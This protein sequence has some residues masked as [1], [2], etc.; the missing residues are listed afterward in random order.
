MNPDCEA[1]DS[2]KSCFII[3]R[4]FSLKPKMNKQKVIVKKNFVKL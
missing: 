2:F 1:S 3:N 4:P